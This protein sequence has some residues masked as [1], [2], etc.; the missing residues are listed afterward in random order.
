MVRG[1]PQQYAV[2]FAV[3][4]AMKKAVYGPEDSGHHALAAD[5]YCHFTSPIRRYPDLTIHRLLEHPTRRKAR[6]P[7]VDHLVLLGAHCSE[8]EQRAE[9]AERELTRLKLL[10]YLEP[11]IGQVM[12][13]VVTGVESFGAFAQLSEI[14]V[15]GLILI[16]SL[17]QDDYY[18]DAESCALCGRRRGNVIRLG[19]VLQVEVAHVDLDR[20]ELDL[21][22]AGRADRTGTMSGARPAKPS[23]R[24]KKAPTSAT[25]KRKPVRRKTRR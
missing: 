6:P 17:D 19:D 18:F 13:A 2:N 22:Y 23:V 10:R 12:E 16:D 7:D 25:K 15:E 14:P 24:S 21:H 20:R 3:L 4:R 9:L 8:R 5:C 11:R 1:R